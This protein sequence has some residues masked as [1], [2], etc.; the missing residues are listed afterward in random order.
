MLCCKTNTKVKYP[1]PPGYDLNKPI[2]INLPLE[3]DEI[4][5]LNYYEKDKTIFAISDEKGI[6][7]KI[8]PNISISKWKFSNGADFEDI[9]RI[10]TTFYILQSNGDIFKVNYNNNQVATESFSFPYGKKNE[11]EIIYNDKESN[12]LILIC[13]DCESDKK[14]SLTTFLFDPSTNLFSDSSFSIDI[15]RMDKL[16]KKKRIKFKPSAAALNPAD[17]LLYIV[18][19]INKIILVADR[20]GE[21]KN[22][23]PI[24][25]A[26]FKQPEGITFTDKGDM[27]IS[28]EFA[29][30]GTANLLVFKYGKTRQ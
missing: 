2:K 25:P 16:L 24:D 22:A 30:A 18:S 7:F 9:T 4:S 26:L 6:I 20:K 13:K 28:N 11:F 19:S 3:L 14:K 10:D 23:Y 17:S 12:K 8:R 15:K 1:S 5:G 21:V 27:I 29:K